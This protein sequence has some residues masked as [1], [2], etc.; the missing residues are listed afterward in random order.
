MDAEFLSH[1]SYA[2][3]LTIQVHPNNKEYARNSS[4]SNLHDAF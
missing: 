4:A 2:I 1:Y 3:P